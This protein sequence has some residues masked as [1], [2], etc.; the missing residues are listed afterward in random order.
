MQTTAPWKLQFRM[1]FFTVIPHQLSQPQSSEPR[2]AVVLQGTKRVVLEEEEYVYGESQFVL[3]AVDVPVI[4]QVV[5][6]TREKPYCCFL[7]KLDLEMARQIISDFEAPVTD[8]MFPGYGV[9]TGPATRELL[10]AVYRLLRLLS[11]PGDIPILSNL[12]KREIIYRLLT[13]GQG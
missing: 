6:A 13:S 12:I 1:S 8:S 9:S 11:T 10:D 2:I 3:T 7:L 4:A 5:E